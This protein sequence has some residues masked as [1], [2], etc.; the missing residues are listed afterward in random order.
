MK[1]GNNMLFQITLKSARNNVN[2]KVLEMAKALGIGKDTYLKWEHNSALVPA[3]Y[4]SKISEI[5]KVP[6][7][8]IFF[9]SKLA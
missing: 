6:I 2:L 1:G 5:T 4:Q 3:I 9:G 8:Y 7:E